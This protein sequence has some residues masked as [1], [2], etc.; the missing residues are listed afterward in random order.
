MSL[1]CRKRH[2]TTRDVI[3]ETPRGAAASGAPAKQAPPLHLPSS[4]RRPHDC[5]RYCAGRLRAGVRRSLPCR[6]RHAT[7][8]DVIR[9]TPGGAAASGAPAK[10]VPPVHPPS[11]TRRP[12]DY[13]RC[14]AGHS[15]AGAR[16]VR[17]P[18]HGSSDQGSPGSGTLVVTA[19]NQIPA[20]SKVT[21]TPAFGSE[22]CQLQVGRP[23]APQIRCSR[24]PV[25]V[26]RKR[27]G[28][29]RAT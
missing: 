26:R 1:P 29:R 15:R 5:G 27:R 9:G 6:K 19:Y 4:T 14:C 16:L 17:G 24:T 7:T 22:S 20:H 3:R 21:T 25:G 18:T 12:R 23:H 11:S 10:Q 13:G 28:L 2:G 8:R